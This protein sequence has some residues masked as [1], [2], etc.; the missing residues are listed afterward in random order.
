ML[1]NLPNL[2]ILVFI[3]E[4]LV[5]R[6]IPYCTAIHSIEIDTNINSSNMPF[7]KI[8]S[9]DRKLIFATHVAS[10]KKLKLKIKKNGEGKT[11]LKIK[12]GDK[13]FF[14]S[15]K[16]DF[17]KD[18]KKLFKLKKRFEVRSGFAHIF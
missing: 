3:M 5:Y 2:H 12:A 17:V 13:H 8:Y 10:L 14:I 11:M 1:H 7:I 16:P 15:A 6:R 18:C 4:K 9:N